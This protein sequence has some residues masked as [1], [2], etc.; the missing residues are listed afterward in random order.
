M[1]LFPNVLTQ[2]HKFHCTRPKVTKNEMSEENNWENY[3]EKTME[4]QI[5][6]ETWKTV[7]LENWNVQETD[8]K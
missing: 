5:S 2:S 1:T 6:Y 8:G 7:K 4:G 3:W